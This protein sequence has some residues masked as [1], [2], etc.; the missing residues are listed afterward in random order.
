MSSFWDGSVHISVRGVMHKWY[1]LE[2]QENNLNEMSIAH[3]KHKTR[4][5]TLMRFEIQLNVQQ[6]WYK[7]T[8]Q[9]KLHFVCN[10]K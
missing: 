5:W 10:K 2:P 3:L 4:E 7:Q 8:K 9:S 1:I 6:L